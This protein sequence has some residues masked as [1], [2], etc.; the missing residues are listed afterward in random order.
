MARPHEKQ[1]TVVIVGGGFGG[2]FA[3]KRFRGSPARVV[4]VDRANHHLFQPLLYQVAT[5]G[6]SPANIAAPIRS[7]LS[8]QDRLE[9]ML[10]EALG[11]DAEEKELILSDR[12]VSYDYLILATGARHSYFGHPEW[13]EHAPGLKT[14]E[15]ATRIRRNILLAVEQAE[16]ATTE[17]R[18]RAC[19]TFVIVG[20]GATGVE[21]AGSIAELAHRVLTRDYD[22]IDL[23]SAR[24]VLLE[25][26]DRVLPSFSRKLSRLAE[27]SLRRLGVDVRTKTRVDEVDAGGVLAGGERIEACNVIWA[28]GVRASPAAEWLGVEADRSGRVPVD[29]R[30]E[31]PGRPGVFAIGDTARFEGP[32]GE[33][34]PGVSQVA[35]QQGAYVAKLIR[36][37][38]EGKEDLEPFHY[39]D[40]GSMATIGR[41]SAVASVKGLEFGGL[42]AWLLWLFVHVYYL[43]G[44]A[45]RLLVLMQWAWAYASFHRGARLITHP[46]R[47]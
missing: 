25:A 47:D 29:E 36:R 27:S 13:E 22:H 3:A 18:K 37:R 31:V 2:L 15:D 8:R 10:A 45:N 39:N 4:L 35:M 19:L 42:F 21:M 5:A 41:A 46:G 23:Q 20:A 43:I 6:L 12:R 28:A 11:V 1:P 40:K 34:L 26:E 24:I 9:V 17:E 7:V 30:C 44:F 32:D 38:M 16:M 14:V 33:P